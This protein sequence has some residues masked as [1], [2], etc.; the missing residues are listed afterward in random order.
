MDNIRLD[1]YSFNNNYTMYR[2]DSIESTNDFFKE[3]YPLFKDKDCLVARRQTK[4]RGRYDRVWSSDD[5]II[6]SILFK[7][8]HN[9]TIIAPMAV[10]LA[11]KEVGINAGIKWPNDVYV[12][13]KKICGI[14][15][16]DEYKSNFEASIV[17]IGLNM[18]SKKEYDAPGVLD[19]V[20]VG[21]D[22][23]IDIILKKY[24]ILLKQEPKSLMKRYQELSIIINK[25]FK[26]KGEMYLAVSIT[27]DGYLVG[28]NSSGQII[29]KS[30][31]IDIKRAL[32]M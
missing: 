26:Y 27:S 23:L 9:N 17:G 24:D 16:E 31:E 3:N 15:I 1:N 4:G 29:I 6:M 21:K 14:L 10:C 30:D 2:V 22:C 7:E 28:E 12:D 11:L 18:T 25:Y 8:H 20:S 32:T 5:D 13:S 19:Y